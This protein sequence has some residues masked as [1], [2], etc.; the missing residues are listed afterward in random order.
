M[1]FLPGVSN[2]KASG[3]CDRKWVKMPFSSDIILCTFKNSLEKF[4]YPLVFR[5]NVQKFAARFLNTFK[6]IKYFHK[7]TKLT[8]I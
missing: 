1:V 4:Q 5:P 8:L 2:A 3:R 7:T 6:I